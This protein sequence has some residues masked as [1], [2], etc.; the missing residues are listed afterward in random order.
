MP[1]EPQHRALHRDKVLTAFL[2]FPA[3]EIAQGKVWVQSG[4]TWIHTLTAA[5][6]L[7]TYTVQ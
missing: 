6:A 1:G 7:K 3:D 2:H 5:T 4:L